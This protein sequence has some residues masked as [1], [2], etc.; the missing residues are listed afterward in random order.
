MAALCAEM[1]ICSRGRARALLSLMQW[2][3]QIA[4]VESPRDR[5][6]KPLAPTDLM[7][8]LQ[9][10][11]WR[12]MFRSISLLDP[13][14]ADIAQMLESRA[15]FNQMVIAMGLWYRAG[16]RLLSCAPALDT[17]VERDG[18][19]MVLVALMV[20]ADAGGPPPAIAELARAF[21]ISRA[22]VLQ[23]LRVAESRGIVAR[24]DSGAGGLTPA[25]RAA[26]GDFFIALFVLLANCAR[27]A[28]HACPVP[29]DERISRHP[30][31]RAQI[32]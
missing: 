22:Q 8:G 18:G 9:M 4:P 14:Y 11:R 21:H 15:F 10:A 31:A 26:I 17:V 13:R 5:R 7:V 27:E 20:R 28:L 29:L 19:L 2:G 30:F 6:E 12:I 25:G 23:V 3:G 32:P 16:H 1:K 24:G